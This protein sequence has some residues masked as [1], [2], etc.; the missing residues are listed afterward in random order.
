MTTTHAADSTAAP[1]TVPVHA[2][3]H[4][5]DTATGITVDFSSLEEALMKIRSRHR[6]GSDPVVLGLRPDMTGEHFST[7]TLWAVS[8]ED[9][10]AVNAPEQGTDYVLAYSAFSVDTPSGHRRSVHLAG[11]NRIASQLATQAGAPVTLTSAL[12]G[13]TEQTMPPVT[14]DVEPATTQADP[15]EL[16]TGLTDAATSEPTSTE[17][18]P[19][20]Q[21]RAESPGV[22]SVRA[23]TPSHAQTPEAA[24]SVAQSA[25]RPGS[26]AHEFATRQE[27]RETR[28]APAEWGWR[29]ALNRGFYLRLG[30]GP[31]E[32]E[33]RALR[34]AIQRP[35]D[36]HRTATVVNIKGGAS[37]STV[38]FLIGATL[39]RIRGGN[40]L[41]WD[42]NENS[43]N[44][45]DRGAP[46]DHSNTAIDLDA[47][48]ETLTSVEHAEKLTRFIRAQGD[49]R[50]H[51]LA[52]QNEA[53][54]KGTIDAAAFRRMHYPLSTFY[55]QIIVDTGNASNAEPWQAAV[56]VADQYVLAGTAK[57][58]AAHRT[59]VT[60]DAL[61]AQG[62][63][64]TLSNSI[65][66]I[67]K[68]YKTDPA[69]LEEM[70]ARLSEHLRAVVVIPWDPTLDTGQY[71]AW[72]ALRPQTRTAYMRAT[73][74]LIEGM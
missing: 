5:T 58:D 72:E 19:D 73:A 61:R 25:T 26:T 70:Q 52:S 66:V 24:Q 63:G 21:D 65:G 39:G 30:P 11:L 40:I 67:T 50:F 47:Q 12:L 36:G 74:A 17:S 43:G 27:A 2:K 55:S 62:H 29:S 3:V 32:K 45:A 18:T 60:L 33:H 71:I 34:R 54:D 22:E 57:E 8:A 31:A 37:K 53:A 41:A 56:D 51:I 4:L 23:S 6:A 7:A 13:F 28:T 20:Q 46:A 44:L 1:I 59:F 10:T 42:N 14:E 48:I 64:R 49:D 38:S 35:L 69:L 68:P 15:A 9:I 16:S